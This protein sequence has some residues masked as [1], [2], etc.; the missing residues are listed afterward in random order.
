MALSPLVVALEISESPPNPPSITLKKDRFIPL[1]IIY[2]R[3]APD[4]PTNAPVTIKR[5]FP[6]VKPMPQAAHPE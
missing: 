5:L 4:E 3:M 1:H 2:D 6:S